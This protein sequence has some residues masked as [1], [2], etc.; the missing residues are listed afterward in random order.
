MSDPARPAA[1]EQRLQ[2]AVEQ[3]RAR[4]TAR[5]SE[6]AALAASRRRGLELR[7]ATKL[8]R[9]SGSDAVSNLSPSLPKPQVRES[10]PVGKSGTGGPSSAS[11]T[12]NNTPHDEQRE[13]Q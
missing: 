4:R 13:Q 7:H 11:T 1:W 12:S 5:R 9:A 8:A 10:S 2:S 3:A 6:R